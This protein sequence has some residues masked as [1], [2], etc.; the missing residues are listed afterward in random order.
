MSAC[1]GRDGGPK[2]ETWNIMEP[3]V[4]T[5]V[6]CASLGFLSSILDVRPLRQHPD[7]QV[8]PAAIWPVARSPGTL[9]LPIPMAHSCA[10]TVY[11]HPSLPT[12]GDTGKAP[13]AMLR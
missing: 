12:D 7:P 4:S 1:L 13:R 8:D 5:H 9:P 6:L 10:Y 11:E 3:Y 2:M